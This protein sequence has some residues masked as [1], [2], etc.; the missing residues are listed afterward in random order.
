MN[1][2]LNGDLSTLKYPIVF[3]F[4]KNLIKDFRNEEKLISFKGDMF[5]DIT[6]E[7]NSFE[8]VFSTSSDREVIPISLEGNC[9]Y[10]IFENNIIT[11]SSLDYFLYVKGVYNVKID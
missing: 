2:I 6:I 10:L 3:N 5:T 11:N 8:N 1:V 7:N 9:R 4:T